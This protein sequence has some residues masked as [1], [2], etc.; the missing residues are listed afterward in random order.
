[1]ETQLKAN[2]LNCVLVFSLSG[3][4]LHK[5]LSGLL[6]D[7]GKVLFGVATPGT[8]PHLTHSP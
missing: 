6:T 1:M 2:P 7:P 4:E 8:A 5:S 3:D